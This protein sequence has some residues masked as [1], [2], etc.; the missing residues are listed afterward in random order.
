VRPNDDTKTFAGR[1]LTFAELR[2]R[3]QQLAQVPDADLTPNS[4]L[5]FSSPKA[6]EKEWRH[7]I[8]GSQAISSARYQLRGEP[9]ISSTDVPTSLLAF[10]TGCCAEYQPPEVFVLDTALSD[11]RYFIGECNCFNG[12]GFYQ[13]DIGPI[14]F[15][16][17]NL[18][19]KKA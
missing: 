6:I 3:Q 10:V 7:F 15:A 5:V 11:G 12:T 19:R 14:V 13:H 8:V 9:S 1:V 2:E 16:V 17:T 4:L 18:L